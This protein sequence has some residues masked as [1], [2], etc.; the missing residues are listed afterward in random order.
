[1]KPRKVCNHTYDITA[2]R[3]ILKNIILPFEQSNKL[4]GTAL[5][6]AIKTVMSHHIKVML[7]C[8]SVKNTFLWHFSTVTNATTQ[9][10][11]VRIHTKLQTVQYCPNVRCILKLLSEIKNHL[12]NKWIW[13]SMA[14]V[15]IMVNCAM[16]SARTETAVATVSKQGGAQQMVSWS[17]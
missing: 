14:A 10:S 12:F 6:S 7:S 3:K 15:L 11:N 16:C 9:L 2:L 17:V 1:M 8:V 4:G 13:I 5:S